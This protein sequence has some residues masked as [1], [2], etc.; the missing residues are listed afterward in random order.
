MRFG[1][2]ASSV[3]AVSALCFVGCSSDKGGQNS[4]GQSDMSSSTSNQGMNGSS[5]S[6]TSRQRAYHSNDASADRP[7]TDG[8]G[9]YPQAEQPNVRTTPDNQQGQ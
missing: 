6:Q 3:L 7:M 4:G 9:K 8:T 5:D 1:F 2:V